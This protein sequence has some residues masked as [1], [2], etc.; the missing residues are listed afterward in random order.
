MNLTWGGYSDFIEREFTANS[1]SKYNT[2]L[3]P[4]SKYDTILTKLDLEIIAL[5][6][7]IRETYKKMNNLPNSPERLKLYNKMQQLRKKQEKLVYANGGWKNFEHLLR[8]GSI[9]DELLEE[10]K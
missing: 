8:D 5:E 9:K 2:T 10:V 6:K 1:V 7:K 3:N 4:V